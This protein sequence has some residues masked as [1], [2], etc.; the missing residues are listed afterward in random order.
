MRR[1]LR[2][3]RIAVVPLVVLVAGTFVVSSSL[4]TGN[5]SG[6]SVPSLGPLD[7]YLCYTSKAPGKNFPQRA[8]S[9]WLQNQFN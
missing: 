8:N 6:T 7:H 1:V 2:K 9:V 4:N 3:R 5:A